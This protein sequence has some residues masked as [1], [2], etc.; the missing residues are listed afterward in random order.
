M[1]ITTAKLNLTDLKQPISHVSAKGFTLIELMIIVAIAS[2]LATVTVQ[3]YSGYVEDA[4]VSKAIGDLKLIEVTLERHRSNAGGYPA[5]LS[6]FGD[7][8][9][10]DPWG[11]AYVF[12]NIEDGGK[13]IKGKVRKDKNLTP[14]NSDYDL[15]SLGKDGA[16]KLPLPPKE[17]HD[18]IIRAS[19]GAYAGLAVD[20]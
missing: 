11:N 16:S 7:T 2:I 1:S 18:D 10:T 9:P 15:Y 14:L 8:I 4:K 17:S 6:A 13:G 3:A 12:L 19:N 20:Y 5:D